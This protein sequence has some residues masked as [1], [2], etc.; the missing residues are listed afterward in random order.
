MN[1]TIKT[2]AIGAVLASCLAAL[3]TPSFK[4]DAKIEVPALSLLEGAKGNPLQVLEDSAR[5]FRKEV[6]GSPVPRKMVSKMP[7]ISP[8]ADVDYKLRIVAPDEA[9]DHKIVI[10]SPAID[11]SK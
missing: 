7:V 11:P 8:S 9:V 2:L 6:I 4:F 1:T 3:E 5:F 10:K